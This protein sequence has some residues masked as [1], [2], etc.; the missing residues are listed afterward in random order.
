MLALFALVAALSPAAQ[1]H[2]TLSAP[3]TSLAVGRP[4]T[5]SLVVRPAPKTRPIVLAR[6][7]SARPLDF[8]ARRVASGRYRVRIIFPRAGKW[9]LAARIG[10]RT[11]RLRTVSVRPQPPPA[12]PLAGATAFH[13]CGGGKAPYPQYAL[14]LGFGSAWIACGSQ[15][16]VQRYNLQSGKLV[17]HIRVSGVPVWSIT[18]GEGAVWTVALGGNVV[19]RIDPTT[20]RVS[21]EIPVGAAVPY[22]W[23][24]AGAVWAVDDSGRSLIRIDPFTN[25]VVTRVPTG[26]GPAGF[27]TN[28][29]AAWVLNHRE[30]SLDEIDPA[31]NGVTRLANGLAPVNTAAV[32]RIALFAGSLWVTGRGVDLLRLSPSTGQVLGRTDIGPAGIGVAS[33]GSHLWIAAYDPVFEPRGIPIASAVARID[34]DG[35]IAARVSPT[36]RLFVDGLAAADGRLWLL[37]SVAGVLLRLPG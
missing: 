8:V 13:V 12:S 26:D 11:I 3:P 5:A 10:A 4:W 17:A 30:N 27:V 7:G 37:D 24:G 29:S 23:A 16:E 21:A 32:E 31:T 35:G 9:A 6:N 28:G 2:A 14:A 18:A 34:S 25:Q 19:Y 22:L 36:T 33:D 1:P 15:A 20:N